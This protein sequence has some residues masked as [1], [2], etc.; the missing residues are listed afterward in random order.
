MIWVYRTAQFLNLKR[1]AIE[2]EN[3]IKALQVG[4]LCL[5]QVV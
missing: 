3:K 4:L 5:L 1:V 2:H